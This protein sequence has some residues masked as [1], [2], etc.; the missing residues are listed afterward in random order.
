VDH[1]GLPHAVA[2]SLVFIAA[3]AGHAVDT[4][5]GRSGREIEVVQLVESVAIFR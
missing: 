3:G 5:P 4:M 2:D 1:V